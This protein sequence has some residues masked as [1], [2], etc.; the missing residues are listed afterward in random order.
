MTTEPMGGPIPDELCAALERVRDI[1]N[2]PEVVR[3]LQWNARLLDDAG[4]VAD[5][6]SSLLL[7]AAAG[8]YDAGLS[9]AEAVELQ[10]ATMRVHDAGMTEDLK[11]ELAECTLRFAAGLDATP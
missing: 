5:A 10:S 3:A 2:N 6:V 11:R 7:G 4:V 9:H 1:L 8:K